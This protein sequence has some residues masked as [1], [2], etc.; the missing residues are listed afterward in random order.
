MKWGSSLN[1]AN[2]IKNTLVN[3]NAD[4]NQE[5]SNEKV[6]DKIQEKNTDS[7]K[8]NPSSEVL[9]SH[10]SFMTGNGFDNKGKFVKHL[11]NCFFV[12]TL[13]QSTILF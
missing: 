7:D 3:R 6:Q 10:S 5:K 9:S 2:H 1:L 13:T 8:Q 4:K 12:I 11:I